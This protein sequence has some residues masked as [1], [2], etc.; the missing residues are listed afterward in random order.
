MVVVEVG[1]MMMANF[2]LSISYVPDTKLNILG[3]VL[4]SQI[5]GAAFCL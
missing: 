2:L 1:A 3:Y 4:L 5:L